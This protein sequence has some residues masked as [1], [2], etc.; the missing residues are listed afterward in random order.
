MKDIITGLTNKALGIKP[1]GYD[2][3]KAI[4]QECPFRKGIRCGVCGCFIDAKVRS[5][6]PCPKHKF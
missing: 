5:K 6:S 1:K 3:K 4:C 2:E